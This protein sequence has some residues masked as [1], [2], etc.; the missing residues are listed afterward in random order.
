MITLLKIFN[1]KF[2]ILVMNCQLLIMIPL[3]LL[4]PASPNINRTEV[5]NKFMSIAVS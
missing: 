1:I 5:I 4:A 3:Q 2:R